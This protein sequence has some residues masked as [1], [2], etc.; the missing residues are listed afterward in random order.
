MIIDG[1][2]VVYIQADPNISA[3][4]R[5]ESNLDG[6]IGYRYKRIRE[7]KSTI[8]GVHDRSASVNID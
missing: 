5:T 1:T 4:N 6:G 3:Y 2:A 8:A 7:H